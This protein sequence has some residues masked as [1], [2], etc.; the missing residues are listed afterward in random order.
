M[1]Q[2]HRKALYT[3][4]VAQP[5]GWQVA[6]LHVARRKD[7]RP[8]LYIPQKDYNARESPVYCAEIDVRKRIT[9]LGV[10]GL[11]GLSSDRF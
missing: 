11:D 6:P 5:N 8:G 9:R 4:I 3:T 1:A 2:Y 10:G 7:E